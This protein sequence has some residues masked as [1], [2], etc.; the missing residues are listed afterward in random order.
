[1]TLISTTKAK[2]ALGLVGRQLDKLCE[3]GRIWYT[4]TATGRKM[5]DTANLT[6]A[7]LIKKVRYQT[8]AQKFKAMGYI[9]APQ[10][11]EILGKH[12]KSIYNFVN[13]GRIQ[14]FVTSNGRK[15]F[16]P[17]N[18]EVI[19]LPNNSKKGTALEY[20]IVMP[21]D[22]YSRENALIMAKDVADKFSKSSST[23]AMGNPHDWIESVEDCY[24]MKGQSFVNLIKKIVINRIDDFFSPAIA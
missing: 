9:T 14:T 5:F 21:E 3:Q 15:F 11:A 2:A 8:D 10:V 24:E 13:S 7:P 20:D 19:P 1:M 22:E 4:V 17:N 23:E 6:I 18:L 16:D 12:I